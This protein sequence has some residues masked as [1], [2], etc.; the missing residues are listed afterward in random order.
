MDFEVQHDE[1]ARKYFALIDG[2]ESVLEY[3][4]VG[5]R[6]LNLFHTYVPPEQRGRGIA[7]EIVRHALDDVERRGFKVVPSCWF[8]RVYMQRPT[9]YHPLLAP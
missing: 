1:N 7:D 3:S 4:E 5:E 6:T 9:R 8:V 2:K